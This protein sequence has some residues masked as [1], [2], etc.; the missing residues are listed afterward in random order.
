MCYKIQLIIE[1]LSF[2]LALV[3]AMYNLKRLSPEDARDGF[4]HWKLHVAAFLEKNWVTLFGPQMKKRKTWLGTISGTMSHWSG[5]IFRSG[6]VSLK[7]SG[8]WKLISDEQPRDLLASA[9]SSISRVGQ[10]TA[11]G[12]SLLKKNKTEVSPDS[13]DIEK[14]S[15][16]E[17]HNQSSQ[18]PILPTP[19]INQAAGIYYFLSQ[20]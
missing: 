8:W 18:N 7:E 15:R 5:V 2:T 11:N 4:Y 14:K 6:L 3:L 13:N 20:P 9:P 17:E 1:H 12:I 10:G 19:S 16:L